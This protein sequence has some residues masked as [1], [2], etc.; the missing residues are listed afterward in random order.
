[1]EITV[2]DIILALQSLIKDRDFTVY[3]LQVAQRQGKRGYAQKHAIHLRYVKSR[4]K[5]LSD[6]LE[7]KLKGTITTVKYSYH[8]GC[9][10]VVTVE[11]EFTNLSEQE[12]RDIMEVQAIIYKMDITILE[13]KE[14][15]TQVRII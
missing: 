6:K 9:G 13:I 10:G 8:N 1:M 3:Q 15:P 7:K 5:D 12:I 11:Q 14:I 4:I 2:R